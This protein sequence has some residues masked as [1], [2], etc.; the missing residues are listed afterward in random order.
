M[1]IVGCL[2]AGIGVGMLFDQTAAGTLIGLGV[3][4]VLEHAL[5]TRKR[6]DDTSGG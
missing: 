3:G 5:Q 1:V 4:F 6:G 2:L